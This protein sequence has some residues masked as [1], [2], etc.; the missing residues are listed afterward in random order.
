METAAKPFIE[1]MLLGRSVSLTKHAVEIVAAWITLKMILYDAVVEREAVF[2]REEALQFAADRRAPSAVKIWIFRT[3]EQERRAYISKSFANMSHI[4]GPG[5]EKA[6][7]QTTAFVTG[8][9]AAFFVLN[10]LSKLEID[11]P[12]QLRGKR[13][14]PPRGP[15]VGWPPL[16]DVTA[17]EIVDQ[18]LALRR[19]VA[20]R[21][22]LV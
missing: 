9:L 11:E 13:L 22:I 20:E 19:F 18:A 8:R 4:L 21:G 14:W 15:V 7:I 1:P 6:N 10:R 5:R 12:S 17:Q 2:T 16:R 3:K